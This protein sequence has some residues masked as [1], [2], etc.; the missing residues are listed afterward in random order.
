MAI[1][2]GSVN[3]V[4]LV[5]N[6]G[7]KPELNQTKNGTAVTTLALA[8]GEIRKDSDGKKH[9]HTE[10]HRIVVWRR[11]AEIAAEYLKKGSKVYVE[12]S[13]RTRAWEDEDGNTRT[14]TE[15]LGERFTMLDSKKEET[16]SV[17]PPEQDVPAEASELSEADDSPL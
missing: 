5:G 7:A 15:V 1:G 2:K 8:T 11:L 3:R 10:W 16:L 12:G 17:A 9:E 13:L 6:L 4:T 14:V